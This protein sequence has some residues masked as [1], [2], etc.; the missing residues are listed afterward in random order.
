M[1]EQYS[2]SKIAQQSPDL[3]HDNDPSV[4]LVQDY[5]LESLEDVNLIDQWRRGLPSFFWAAVAVTTA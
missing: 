2:D 3:P 5:T 4:E 1:S